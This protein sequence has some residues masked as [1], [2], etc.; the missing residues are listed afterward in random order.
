MDDPE[1]SAKRICDLLLF[2]GIIEILKT[3]MI[4]NYEGILVTKDNDE[5]VNYLIQKFDSFVK[6]PKTLFDL[7]INKKFEKSTK[8]SAEKSTENMIIQKVE[9][10]LNGYIKGKIAVFIH[11]VGKRK[12][13][14]N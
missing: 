14:E 4:E 13:Q 3:I 10:F 8:K 2:R 11:P 9:N 12:R 5:S 7:K 6:S 1:D